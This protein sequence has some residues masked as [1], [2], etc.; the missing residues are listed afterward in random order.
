MCMIYILYINNFINFIL[1]IVRFICMSS[2]M[3]FIIEKLMF[4]KL[5]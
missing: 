1:C 2:V 4:L 5:F 3:N